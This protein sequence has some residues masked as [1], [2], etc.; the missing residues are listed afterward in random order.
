MQA[1]G[2]KRIQDFLVKK[3]KS[4]LSKQDLSKGKARNFEHEVN[5][6]LPPFPQNSTPSPKPN[7]ET[8][9][10]EETIPRF[11]QDQ[12]HCSA[13]QS[14]PLFFLEKLDALQSKRIK[15][16]RIKERLIV[17]RNLKQISHDMQK[18]ISTKVTQNVKVLG[19][20]S[21]ELH[22]MMERREERHFRI[23][24]IIRYLAE[25]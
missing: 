17:I 19:Q 24:R 25:P 8:K 15:T 12:L 6:L 18:W 9:V 4:L 14:Y 21:I 5:T 3:R 20:E 13:N 10:I 1:D 23:D 16:F 22:Q 2:F 7:R 11:A